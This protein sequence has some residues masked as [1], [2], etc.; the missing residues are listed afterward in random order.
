M[1]EE[2]VTAV[3]GYQVSPFGSSPEE[4]AALILEPVA[5]LSPEDMAKSEKTRPPPAA[6]P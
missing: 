4:A 2:P 1:E 3:P 5:L 6:V